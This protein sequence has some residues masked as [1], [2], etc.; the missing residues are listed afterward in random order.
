[1]GRAAHVEVRIAH[2]GARVKASHAGAAGTPLGA[3]VSP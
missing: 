3:I 2:D 1:V